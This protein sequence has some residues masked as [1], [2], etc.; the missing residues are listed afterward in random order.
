MTKEIPKNKQVER[1]VYFYKAVCSVDGTEM[2]L[3]SVFDTYISKLDNNYQNLEERGLAIPHYDKFHFLDIS[4]HD[5]DNNVY[6]GKFY[7]LRSTDFPYLFNVKSG[8]RQEISVNDQDTL[9]EQTHFICY[10]N[11]RLIASEYNFYGARIEKLADYLLRI[12]FQA[13]PSKSCNISIVPIIIPEYFEQI[14]DCSTIS[15]VQ[16]KVSHPGIKILT[17]EKLLGVSDLAKGNIDEDT[18]F[19]IDV[20]LSGGRGKSLSIDKKDSFLER[21][22][23]AIRKGNEYDKTKKDDD[24]PAFRKAKIKAYNPNEGKLIPYDLLDEKLVYTCKVEKISSKSKYV[25]SEKMYAEIMNAYKQKK[26]D[27]LRYMKTI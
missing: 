9:M 1:K 14:R 2:K 25:D 16:F 13:F 26:E 5:F 10:T 19:Y 11:Q 21:I 12:M 4:Q 6:Y 3:N 27:A 18:N 22:I 24:E 15:K 20:E 23:S 8:D 17:E 7:S